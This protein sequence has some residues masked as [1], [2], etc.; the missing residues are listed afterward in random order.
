MA[1]MRGLGL[2]RVATARAGLEL[3]VG[4]D[5]Y[6]RHLARAMSGFALGL[7]ALAALAWSLP[8][9][10]DPATHFGWIFVLA[11][12]Q[13]PVA[14]LWWF[15]GYRWP[16]ATTVIIVIT[17][18]VRLPAVVALAGPSYPETA[19]LL[20]V[21]AACGWVFLSRKTAM[22]TGTGAALA[23]LAVLALQSG[24]P[25]PLLRWSIVVGV[26]AL[27][28]AVLVWIIGRVEELASA[29]TQARCTAEASS[30]ELQVAYEQLAE[31]NRTLEAR[32]D[33]Q[34]EEIEGLGRLRRFLSTPVADAVISAERPELLQPH[35]R[36]IAVFFCDLRGFTAFSTS[37]QPEEVGD[38][39]GEYFALLGAFVHDYEATVG[40]FTGDGL[41]AFFNDP[42]TV[43]QPA[44]RAIS[45]AAEVS[46]AMEDLRQS[47][48]LRGYDLGF[49][50][51]VAYGYANIGMIGF[52]G[53]R[54]Y[55]ALGPVVNLASRLCSEAHD[56]EILI[57]LQAHAAAADAIVVGAPRDILIKG[58]ALP[59]TVYAVESVRTGIV[60]PVDEPA[61]E[62]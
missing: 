56:G 59:V 35:R 28:G 29:E 17:D 37:A 39:L 57:D 36:R 6:P 13:A 42:L 10:A 31:L 15:H 33:A 7:V 18:V 53:R 45:M 44:L 41:M 34:V 50:V 19:V 4:P 43:D 9:P 8:R 51:G 38:V 20:S 40:A 62:L 16:T 11:V 32:V 60:A 1:R 30:L 46:T 58:I 48:E 55:T 61:V 2:H 27:A 25:A 14:V 12:V 24:H 23:Y 21:S 47:W 3:L 52:E 5:R 54:D 49:G 22:L 26:S